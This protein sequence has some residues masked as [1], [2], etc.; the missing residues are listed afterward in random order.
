M[1]ITIPKPCHENWE[2]MTPAEK[3]RFC[4][5]CSKTV[6]DFTIASDD[7]IIEVISNATDKDICGNFYDSQLNRNLQYS[8]IN[9]IFVKFAVGFILTTGGFVSL[10]AQENKPNVMI[11]KVPGLVINQ[12]KDTLSR[13]QMTVGGISSGVRND[14][15]ALVV[16]DGKVISLKDF[17]ALDSNSIKTVNVLK[18]ASATAIYGAPAQN[19]VII[20]T[21]KKK[22]KDRKNK[23]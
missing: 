3:G 13:R 2:M 7:E 10:Q 12:P 17:E 5:V 21:T 20:I 11:N 15:K 19:G 4:S 9:S 22:F 1:K 18:G 8:Y 14:Q 6:R 23:I 16:M